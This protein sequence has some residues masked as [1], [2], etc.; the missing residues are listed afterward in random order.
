MLG[1]SPVAQQVKNLPAMQET[2]KMRVWSL[3]REDPLEEEMATHS[4]ISHLEN[5]MDRAWWATVHGVAKSRTRL[6]THISLL[7]A[8]SWSRQ[9]PVA[10]LSLPSPNLSAHL[11]AWLTSAGWSQSWAKSRV[12]QRSGVCIRRRMDK[13]HKS[14][15][16]K[17]SNWSKAEEKVSRPDTI[18]ILFCPGP[19]G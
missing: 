2:Q 13:G 15:S 1:A 19:E 12:R 17:K 16:L 4:S 11:A 10:Q 3:R 14:I 8:S 5:S 6:R 7:K 9:Y 18:L